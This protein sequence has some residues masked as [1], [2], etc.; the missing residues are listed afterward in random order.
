MATGFG[1]PHDTDFD[2]TQVFILE[3]A[4]GDSTGVGSKARPH[5]GRV[6]PAGV[7]ENTSVHDPLY[8][9]ARIPRWSSMEQGKAYVLLLCEARPPSL[10]NRDP[11]SVS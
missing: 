9:L 5:A 4:C 10:P 7:V 11:L 8:A 1:V 3:T 2:G 6:S